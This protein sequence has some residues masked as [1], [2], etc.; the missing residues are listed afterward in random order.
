MKSRFKA[1]EMGIFAVVSLIFLNSVYNL[2]TDGKFIGDNDR[3]AMGTPK[4]PVLPNAENTSGRRQVASEGISG[5]APYETKCQTTGEVFETK[6]AK[7]RIL[8]P[9]CGATG[10]QVAAAGEAKAD[11]GLIE[12]KIE[13]VT[14]HYAATVFSDHASGK[15]STDFIPLE[16]G[17]NRIAMEFRY[18]NGKV[19]PVELT[20]VRK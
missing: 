19:F 14:T 4:P 8:G 13:N 6:A 16:A 9:F 18:K 1:V 10:R 5:F 7:V 15:F 11:A 3:Q 12:Y 17:E 20:I 2:F